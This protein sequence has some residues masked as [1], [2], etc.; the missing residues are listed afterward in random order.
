ME[1]LQAANLQ[2]VQVA[3]GKKGLNIVNNGQPFPAISWTPAGV[4]LLAT[5][6]P[7]LGGVPADQVRGIVNVID[8]TDVGL[9]I[10]LPCAEEAPAGDAAEAPVF[11]TVESGRFRPAHHS[12][13]VLQMDADGKVTQIGNVAMADVASMV[14]R[15]RLCC[16]PMWWISSKRPAPNSCRLWQTAKAIL[17]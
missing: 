12:G 7:T 17:T 6:A 14:F 15:R 2:N 8:Q 9:N 5:L 16:L 13:A 10:A 3:L 11:C 1:Q 4:D